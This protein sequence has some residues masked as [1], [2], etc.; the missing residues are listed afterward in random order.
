MN[1]FVIGKVVEPET[2]N[3]NERETGKQRQV[4]SFGLLSGRSC[5]TFDV[6]DNDKAFEKVQTLKEGA[7]VIAIV[8][9]SVDD[10]GRFRTYIN[11]VG[12]CPAELRTQ[13]L[14]AVKG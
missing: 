8:G 7:T 10:K 11:G 14:A 2:R 6:Y 9:S 1:S 3:F 13:L 4:H 5:T 12:P